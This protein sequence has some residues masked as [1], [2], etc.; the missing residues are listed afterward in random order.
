M[1]PRA[2]TALIAAIGLP[3][4]L[5][6]QADTLALIR[7][8]AG[9]YVLTVGPWTGP[10][11]PA[12]GGSTAHTPPSLFRLDTV[13]VQT[14]PSLRL[15]V[16]P[17]RLVAGRMVASWA[18]TPNDSLGLFWS[19]GFVGVRLRLAIHGDSLDWHRNHVSR[20]ALCWRAARSFSC[21]GRN[22]NCVSVEAI[23]AVVYRSLNLTS[24]LRIARFAPF[25]LI[26]CR[27]TRTLRGSSV[28]SERWI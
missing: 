8:R 23:V 19:T 26:P 20:C 18:L 14:R 27:L 12:G 3:A 28:E 21:G 25:C 10:L 6:A 22:A 16:Q 4:S 15:A 2:L 7:N 11:P 13:A 24:N 1:V 9:C 5:R 17:A